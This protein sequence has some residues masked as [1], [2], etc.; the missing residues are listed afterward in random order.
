[1]VYNNILDVYA[2]YIIEHI[3]KDIVDDY[4][5]DMNDSLTE[6]LMYCI[7]DY[8]NIDKEIV[9]D[10]AIDYFIRNSLWNLSNKKHFPMILFKNVCTLYEKNI[11][12][13]NKINFDKILYH[14]IKLNSNIIQDYYG[15]IYRIKK[16]YFD[17]GYKIDLYIEKNNLKY[18]L[19]IK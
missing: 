15:I 17:N 4:I 1:M 19:K 13:T 7:L 11:E 3:N 6:I 18:I 12:L 9:N 16:Y 10:D 5:F 14:L 2:K 8:D